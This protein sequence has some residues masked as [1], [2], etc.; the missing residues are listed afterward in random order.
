MILIR[1]PRCGT[2][3]ENTPAGDDRSRRLTEDEADARVLRICSNRT[4]AT[5]VRSLGGRLA[6]GRRGGSAGLLRAPARPGSGG[7]GCVP[8]ARTRRVHG[9]LGED[10]RE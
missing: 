6:R 5:A 3:Y 9:A 10:A 8:A 2:L 4:V 1:C 7:D